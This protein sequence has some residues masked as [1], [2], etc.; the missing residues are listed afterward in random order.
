MKEILLPQIVS[1]GIYNAQIAIRNRSVSKNRKTTMFEIELPIEDGGVSYIDDQS[2]AVSKNVIICAKPGQTRHTRLPFKCYYIHMIVNEGELWDILTTLPNFMDV[3][4]T[5]KIKEIFLALL[6]H[7]QTGIATDEIMLQSL[8]LRLVHILNQT[9]VRFEKSTPK[10]NNHKII[11]QTLEY[12]KQN[13]TAELTLEGLA[14]AA[15]FNPTYFH[16]LFKSST[17]RTLHEYVEDQRIRKAIHLLIS[18]NMTLTQIAYE[19]GF[20]SQ[21][22]FSYAFKRRMGRSPRDYAKKAVVRYNDK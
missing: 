8:I 14:N 2:H 17:G 20:S 9:A 15:S 12:I 5:E 3:E 16:K 19:C 1:V 4:D 11:E 10:S 13:L 6:E 7:Y 21:S 18:T 22:Y